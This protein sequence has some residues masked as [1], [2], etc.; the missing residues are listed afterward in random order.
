MNHQRYCM[1]NIPSTELQLYRH[2][3]RASYILGHFR[4]PNYSLWAE[5]HLHLP[6]ATQAATRTRPNFWR[7]SSLPALDLRCHKSA[8][9]LNGLRHT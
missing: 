2:D 9:S 6:H 8:A 3:T 4:I 5:N 7:T 1:F